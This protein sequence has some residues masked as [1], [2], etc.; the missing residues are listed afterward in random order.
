[1]VNKNVRNRQGLNVT[2]KCAKVCAR[3]RGGK[4]RTPFVSDKDG[5]TRRG[6]EVVGLL[7]VEKVLIGTLGNTGGRKL[8]QGNG[9][10]EK[11]GA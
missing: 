11:N 8:Q 4:T 3:S 2:V 9:P 7:P 6:N 10:P 1:M 5:R